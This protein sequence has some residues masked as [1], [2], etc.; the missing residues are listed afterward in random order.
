MKYKISSY[1]VLILIV[2]LLG[3]LTSGCRSNNSLAPYQLE[4]GNNPDSFQFQVT[5]V[6][7]VTTTVEY[8]W[9]NSGPAASI[10]QSSAISGG[11]ATVELYDPDQV[12]RY[13]KGLGENGTFQSETGKAGT[14]K[15]RVIL[16]NLNGTLNFRMQKK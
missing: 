7:N 12:M 5:G 1:I 6:K 9:Q 10:N 15:I 3:V 8:S 16:N 14:W 4:V 2:T 13:S 11:S